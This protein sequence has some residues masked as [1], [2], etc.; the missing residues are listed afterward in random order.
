ML[1]AQIEA[2]LNFW[3]LYH[4]S[5]DLDKLHVLTPAVCLIGEASILDLEPDLVNERIGAL[6][7]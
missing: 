2:I 1:L 3:P 5:D 4:M 7:P 6:Q